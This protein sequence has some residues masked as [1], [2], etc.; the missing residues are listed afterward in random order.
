MN[1]DLEET[2]AELGPD[3][4]VVVDR[5]RAAHEVAPSRQIRFDAFAKK[6]RVVSWPRVGFLVAASLFVVLAWSIFCQRLPPAPVAGNIYT[7]AY[8]PNEEALAALVA[9]QRAD[10]SWANDY[11]TRQ[12]AAALRDAGG[13]SARLAYR[14]ALRYLRTKGLQPL[15]RE[16]LRARERF[17]AAWRKG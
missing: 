5:L 12:N 10:G 7:V 1:K 2:L 14:R 3:A 4:R 9:S 16:E 11:L 17:A 13:S 8:A 15:T 6:R